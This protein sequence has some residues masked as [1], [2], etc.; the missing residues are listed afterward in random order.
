M[1]L[2]PAADALE[3]LLLEEAEEFDLDLGGQFPDLVEEK[4]AAGGGFDVPLALRVSTSERAFFV[5]EELALQQVLRDRVA[6]DGD[7]R[8]AVLRRSGGGS[9][10]PPFPCRCRF[11]PRIRTGALVGATLRTNSKTACI[12][13]LAPSIS[14]KTS[15]RA[16]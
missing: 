3:A 7:E 10:G 9:P 8:A 11:P 6:V 1:D 5:T 4:G 12:C 15:A 14:S 13:G 16:P 2:L